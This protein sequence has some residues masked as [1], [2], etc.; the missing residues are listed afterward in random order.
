MS[1][2]FSELPPPGNLSPI[3]DQP[4]MD[5]RQLAQSDV[6]ANNAMNRLRVASGGNSYEEELDLHVHSWLSQRIRKQGDAAWLDLCCGEGRALLEVAGK[7]QA[8]I[9]SPPVALHG[10]DLVDFF[11]RQAGEFPT[12]KLEEAD[13]SQ[14]TASQPYDLI[15]CVHG[16]HYVGD[17]LGLVERISQWLRPGGL[18]LAHLDLNNLRGEDQQPLTIRKALRKAGIR[19]S[20]RDHLLRWSRD[21]DSTICFPFEFVGADDQAGPNYTGQPAVN[22]I[23]RSTPE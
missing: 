9:H 21:S 22:S 12:V 23:Y 4:M 11:A 3:V 20:I 16:L 18:F 1:H 15:T 14:W 5:E 10:V 8:D 13:L 6:V 2:F 7:F 17:K 19:Y